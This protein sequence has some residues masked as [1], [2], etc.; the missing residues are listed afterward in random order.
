MHSV[1]DYLCKFGLT[2]PKSVLQIGANAGQEVPMF[3]RNGVEHA[4]LVEPLDA[5]FSNLC[6]ACQGDGAYLP[7]KA[8]AVAKDGLSVTMHVA[9][10]FGQSS[11][12]LKPSNHLKLFPSVEFGQKPLTIIGY[13]ADSIYRYARSIQ[14]ALPE[15][16][17]M[18][19]LDVQGAEL[20][21]LKGAGQLLGN[22]RYIFTE[23]GYGGGYEGNVS[24]ETLIQYLAAF[25]FRLVA[26][27]ID[28]RHGYGDAL[29]VKLGSRGSLS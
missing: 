17:D 9:N 26:M 25:S 29:F 20:E 27:E 15:W 4:V 8:L 23:I 22:A 7:V 11:S 2:L 6:Q 16:V 24:V 3:K 28:P 10:N 12:I 13:T 1:F 21:V 5:P 14:S 18:L 19:F